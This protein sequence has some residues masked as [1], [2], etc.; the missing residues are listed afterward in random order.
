[1]INI[2][3]NKVR[4][5]KSP[6]KAYP[7]DAGFDLYLP[8]FTQ[9]FLSDVV[10]VNRQER[11]S[12][13][14]SELRKL[15]TVYDNKKSLTIAPGES[16]L[17]PSGLKVAVPQGYALVVANKSGIASKRSLLYGA[18]VIDS[19]FRGEVLINL[20]NVGITDQTLTEDMKIVQVLLLPV[21][22]ATFVECGILDE[23]TDRGAGGF[24]STDSK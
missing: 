10:Y 15:Y 6:S 13:K 7:T 20:H 5:V 21:P 22:E 19:S 2:E 24:G 11:E 16:V 8:K 12:L 18:H 14:T 9:Q 3:F 17:I 1:M 23:K 4:E